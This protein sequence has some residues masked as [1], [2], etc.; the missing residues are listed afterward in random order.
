MAQMPA[1]SVGNY[2]GVMLCN[3]PADDAPPTVNPAVEAPRFRPIRSRTPSS[4]PPQNAQIGEFPERV[5]IMGSEP[6]VRV[7]GGWRHSL[8]PNECPDDGSTH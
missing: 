8:H 1:V 3:R 2:K 7:S 6:Y 5:Q 4:V